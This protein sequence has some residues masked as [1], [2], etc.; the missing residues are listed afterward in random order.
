MTIDPSKNS[1]SQLLGIEF[2]IAKQQEALI[3]QVRM[4]EISK[5]CEDTVPCQHVCKITLSNWKNKIIKLDRNEI[6]SLVQEVAYNRFMY[7][8]N[9]LTKH[10]SINDPSFCFSSQKK[11]ESAEDVLVKVF[12][13]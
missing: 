3:G 2:S 12:S 13:E 5:I 4:I 10:F 9:D 7:E 11:I 8:R 1:H 6:A